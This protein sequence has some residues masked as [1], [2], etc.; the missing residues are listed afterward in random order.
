LIIDRDFQTPLL[1]Y[2]QQ[3]LQ[4][5][6]L[7]LIESDPSDTILRQASLK[8][9]HEMV[10]M[11]QFLKQDEINVTVTHLTRQLMCQDKQLK[12]QALATLVIITKLYPTALEEHTFPIL[13]DQLPCLEKQ[14]STNYRD[15]LDAIEVLGVHPAVFMMIVNPL[16]KKLDYACGTI[17][18]S[19]K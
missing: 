18:K 1:M 3:I 12:Q 4:I 7:S 9:I 5:F 8:G 11:K 19:K 13:L 10:L 15:S 2:K 17:G 16:L 6:I 14:Q